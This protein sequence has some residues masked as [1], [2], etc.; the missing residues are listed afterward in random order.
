MAS[1]IARRLKNGEFWY[2]RVK[3]GSGR[4][5]LYN[6]RLL[7]ARTRSGEIVATSRKKAQYA[8][9]ELQA[10]ESAGRDPFRLAAITGLGIA[11][12][13]AIDRYCVD[14]QTEWSPGTMELQRNTLGKLRRAL[15]ER[16]MISITK[17]DLILL[18]QNLV[19]AGARTNSGKRIRDLSNVT[20]NIHLRNLNAFCR[21]CERE[22]ALADWHAPTL[23][24]AR[25]AGA[26]I[27]GYYRPVELRELFETAGMVLQNGRP[28]GPFLAFAV[29]TGMRRNEILAF[30]AAWVV[31]GRQSLLIP[32]RLTKSLRAREIPIDRELCDLLGGVKGWGQHPFGYFREDISKKFRQAAARA[33]LRRLKLHA[34][35]D[36][37]AVRWL[38]LG[39]SL[40]AVKQLL[41]HASIETTEEHYTRLGLEELR[42][43]EKT[44]REWAE[45][46]TVIVRL[47]L[48][49]C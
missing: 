29:L 17:A 19:D 32:A 38:M 47:A 3:L 9:L 28:I 27:G 5:Y 33:G 30:S 10:A 12:A 8:A 42:G 14:R 11:V 36:T 26:E 1:V 22:L 44:R 15:G 37:A 16:A 31:P 13:E 23:R 48:G 35:R 43:D 49:D 40:Q 4:W 20:L 2:A 6:T 39:K 21:W 18:R 34:L 46:G 25:V 7:V 41:G 45:I 24:Q